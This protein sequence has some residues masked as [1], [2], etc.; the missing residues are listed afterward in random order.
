MSLMPGTRLGSYE[1][2]SPLGAGGMGEVYRSRDLKLRREV[3]VTPDGRTLAF[4]VLDPAAREDLWILPLDGD[5][6]QRGPRLVRRSAPARC[7][8][9]AVT[10]L[11]ACFPS[12]PL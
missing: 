2:L 10:L 1:V 9:Q 5:P 11:R 6:Y 8:R 3:A 4:V 7:R 12:H